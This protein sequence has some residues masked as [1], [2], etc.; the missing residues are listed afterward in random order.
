MIGIIKYFLLSLHQID[1]KVVIFIG[2]N[3]YLCMQPDQY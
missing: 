1:Y 3:R 2:Q